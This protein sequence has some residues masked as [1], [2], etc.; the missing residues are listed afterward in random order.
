[1]MSSYLIYFS[2]I[3]W[4]KLNKSQLQYFYTVHFEKFQIM[5]SLDKLIL[6]TKDDQEENFP[7]YCPLSQ[8][9]I[10]TIHL[11]SHCIN[12]QFYYLPN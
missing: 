11:F 6:I 2:N 10:V 4:L 7:C 12:Y 1:M 3:F 8:L 5:F 9:M